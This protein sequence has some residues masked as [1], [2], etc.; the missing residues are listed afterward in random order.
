M[1]LGVDYKTVG[2]TVIVGKNYIDWKRTMTKI[3][4]TLAILLFLLLCNLSTVSAADCVVGKYSSD[5]DDG[6]DAANI[7]TDCSTGKWTSTTG[8]SGASDAACTT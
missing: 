2:T 8:T 1:D 3:P 6:G 7:C 5:G 4:V